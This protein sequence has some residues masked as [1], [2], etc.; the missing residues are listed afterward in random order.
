MEEIIQRLRQFRDERNWQQ[1]HNPK[2]LALALS[3]ETSELLEVFL[4]KPPEAADREKVK[5][6]LADVLAYALLLSDA[7]DFDIKKI[8]LDK[9]DRNE[10]KYPVHKAKGTAKKYNEL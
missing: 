7:Y 5:E 4:W 1:F 6:E 10:Q 9:I 3:I 2:D 8:V